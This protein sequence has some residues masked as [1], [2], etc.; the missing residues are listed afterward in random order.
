MKKKIA[1][2]GAGI[3]GLATGYLLKQHADVTLLEKSD[4]P[5]GWVQTVERDGF[6]F[7]LGPRSCRPKGNGRYTLK[8]IEELGLADEIITGNEAATKRYLF[9]NGRLQQIPSSLLSFIASPLTRPMVL[10]LLKEPWVPPSKESDESIHHFVSR[11]FGEYAANTFFNPLTLGIFAGDTK[12]LSIKN[13]FPSMHEWEQNHRSV[14]RGAFKSK[15]KHSI[16][17]PL[18]ESLQKKPLFTFKRGMQ[19]LIEALAEQLGK[20]IRY[21]TTVTGIDAQENRVTIHTPNGSETYDH[22][23]LCI[24]ANQL[25]N[26]IPPIP[27]IETAETASVVTASIGYRDNTLEKQGFG[28]LV[29][30]SEKEQVLGIVW[31]SSAFPEQ[32]LHPQETRLT[33]MMGGAHHPDLV[34]ADEKTLTNIALDAL[35][36]H[37][38]ITTCPDTLMIRYAR[39]AIPQYHVGHDER[40]AQ[41][42]KTLPKSITLMGN[43]FRGIAINDCIANAYHA[44]VV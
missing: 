42:E 3:T 38:G 30:T 20:Q 41:V 24:P 23:Y 35:K 13:C 2:L 37:L 15:P 19:T 31:D 16:T 18:I 32:N 28:H 7:E 8:L 44:A 26:L 39:D 1:I 10:P 36:R 12:K 17:S 33:V 22:L 21:N 6:L 5:G 11:R 43:S 27:T 25:K 14:I 29:P 34:D 40:V 4:R 9:L